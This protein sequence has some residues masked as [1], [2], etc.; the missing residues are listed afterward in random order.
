MKYSS[1]SEHMSVATF[2]DITRDGDI[3]AQC[4][5]NLVL[6]FADK[7]LKRISMTEF[8]ALMAQCDHIIGECSINDLNVDSSS[9]D[10]ATGWVP[11]LLADLTAMR[12]FGKVLSVDANEKMPRDL[13]VDA[14][15]VHAD[16]EKLSNR[17]RCMIRVGA[18]ATNWARAAW[19]R[20]PFQE[21][22]GTSEG[23][24]LDSDVKKS[25]VEL[26][27]SINDLLCGE[28]VSYIEKLYEVLM[29][30]VTSESH[31]QH[32]DCFSTHMDSL[33]DTEGT[34]STELISLKDGFLQATGKGLE[35]ILNYYDNFAGNLETI[36]GIRCGVGDTSKMTSDADCFKFLSAA[37]KTILTF[38]IGVLERATI[39]EARRRADLLARASAVKMRM[40]GMALENVVCLWS[41][42]WVQEGAITCAPRLADKASSLSS[43]F[44]TF[45]ELVATS[46]ISTPIMSMI[47]QLASSDGCCSVTP[48]VLQTATE[49]AG[50]LPPGVQ[51]I[52]QAMRSYFMV[53]RVMEAKT[54]GKVVGTIQLTNALKSYS[55]MVEPISSKSELAEWKELLI[56]EWSCTF[57]QLV[58][59]LAAGLLE[60]FLQK[61][62][63]GGENIWSL[64]T[65]WS[66]DSDG[67]GSKK[68]RLSSAQ[69]DPTR[70]AEIQGVA[71]FV[72]NLPNAERIVTELKGSFT[73]LAW[74]QADQVKKLGDL[75]ERMG[76]IKQTAKDGAILMG[77]IVLANSAL[78]GVVKDAAQRFVF[79]RL[80]VQKILMPKKLLDALGAEPSPEQTFKEEPPLK[81]CKTE[82]K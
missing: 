2:G 17:V 62:G 10:P 7:V 32:F 57:D 22:A 27:D 77:A 46:P 25:I 48:R 13:R 78:A 61:Y 35:E 38:E 76:S 66:F 72:Q 55:L 16:K 70:E 64:L 47:T 71:S 63:D 3:L 8:T 52:V 21:I 19:E 41:D 53:K 14:L 43:A 44:E 60:A 69:K 20:S 67:E 51:P 42:L 31:S 56:T 80:G 58:T 65:A 12:L 40:P 30:G 49:R 59:D 1:G 50:C 29:V 45:N 23:S 6:T 68:V 18:G 5:H 39:Q 36:Y 33:G 9:I 81:K 79:E 82:V 54:S 75:I 11:Q 4:Q 15:K 37:A 24:E 73:S 34:T 26:R 28:N 74:L